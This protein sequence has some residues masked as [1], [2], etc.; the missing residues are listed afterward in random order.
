VNQAARVARLIGF[1]ALAHEVFHHRVAECLV[2][3]H[4]AKALQVILYHYFKVV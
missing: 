1:G 4:P 2:K 3:N